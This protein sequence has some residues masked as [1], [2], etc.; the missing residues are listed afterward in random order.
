MRM[1]SQARNGRVCSILCCILALAGLSFTKSAHAEKVLVKG[2]S[3]EVYTEGRVGGFLS[4]TYGDGL[5]RPTFQVGADG[6]AV[7]IRAIS[8]G[9]WVVANEQQQII[10]ANHPAAQDLPGQGTVNSMRVR[11]G[12]IGNV[13]GFGV[14][15]DLTPTLKFTAFMQ[16]WAFIESE[17]REKNRPNYVDARQ[18]YVK[19]ES[20][21]GSLLA[22]RTRALFSRGATDIDTQYAHRWGVGF[23]GNFDSSGPTN[24]QIGFGVLGSGFAG[25]II[26]GTPVLAGFQLNVGIFD[27]IRLP[28]NGGWNRTKFARPEAELTYER[29]FGS[30]GKFVAFANGAYQSVYKDGYCSTKQVDANTP[31]APCS[32]TAAGMGYGGRF[33][34]DFFRIGVAGHFGRG[35][36]LNYALE[37]SDA[38]Q[39]LDGHMRKFDGYYAQTQFVLG[40]F[41]LSAGAGIVRVFLTDR[42]NLPENNPADPT[43]PQIITHSVIKDQIG[44]N[45]GVVYNLTPNLHFD[46][47]FFRAQADWYFGE[48]QV[49]YIANTGMIL[50][51]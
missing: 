7:P 20:W 41:D 15:G 17:G 4:Y 13:L 23:P 24:G 46:L 32:E 11:S 48:K 49:L 28:G 1:P 26:Y 29:K 3:W 9:G 34:Y 12:F 43:G 21:W 35:L 45:A 25:G 6:V 10:D 14:R 50:N 22:G 16:L 44:V 18:G 42:D 5:P 47:D 8:G 2:D 19:L 33:E 40:K 36:G 27:P 39:D 37:T 31:A 51:W 30:T 38:A